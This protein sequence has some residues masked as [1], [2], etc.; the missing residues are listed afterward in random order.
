MNENQKF[1]NLQDFLSV[2]RPTHNE[3]SKVVYI[4]VM[5]AIADSKNTISQLLHNIQ[6]EYIIKRGNNIVYTAR[7]GCQS[8]RGIYYSHA[9]KC[10]YVEELN[11]VIPYPG[12]W[13]LFKNYQF[14]L[15]KAYFDE[16]LKTLY[17]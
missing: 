12:D 10:E 2:V 5:D 11:W 7:S 13:H 6:E 8:L 3:A 17:S 16:R 9:L 1:L 15:M 4:E 14:P